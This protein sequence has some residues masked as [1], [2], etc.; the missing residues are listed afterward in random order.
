MST[1]EKCGDRAVTSGVP[2]TVVPPH[3]T[4]SELPADPFVALRV[5][6]GMLLGEDDFRVLMGNPRGKQRLHS[7]W[8]HGPGVVWGMKVSADEGT[9]RIEPGLAID[10][11]GRELRLEATQCLDLATWR[12]SWMTKHDPVDGRYT[13]WL[14]AEF[15]SCATQ[16]VPALADPCDVT[17]RHDEASRIVETV[18][19]VTLAERPGSV[20]AYRRV[21]VLLGLDRPAEGECRDAVDALDAVRATPPGERPAALLAAFHRMAVLDERD[22][23]PSGPD[24]CLAQ[25]PAEDEKAGVVLARLSFGVPG[26][27]ADPDEVEV[28]DAPVRAVLPTTV[29]QDLLCGLAPGIIAPEH[30][31]SD[32]PQLVTGG[33]SRGHDEVALYFDRPI[34]PGSWEGAIEVSSLSTEGRG[35]RDEHVDDVTS[36]HRGRLL[37]VRLDSRPAYELVRVVVKGTGSTPLFG[38]DPVEPF[39]GWV[40]SAAAPRFDGRD[41][42]FNAY[43]P[44]RSDEET[45]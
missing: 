19:I 17:R 31:S 41:A 27:C 3:C 43:L 26:K 23:T 11:M 7:A 4:D 13:A 36:H 34:A 35:W 38:R 25:F 18:R 22:R 39:A 21:R 33:W 16:R 29:I 1:C 5:A 20:Q 2:G 6:Y 24:A 10:E 9:V 37:V 42:A 40:G 8:L 28:S 30:A 12:A 32:G 44:R 14:V 45:T 15:D